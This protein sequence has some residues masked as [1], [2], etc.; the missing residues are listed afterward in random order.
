MEKRLIII[1]E[2]PTEA[3]FTNQVL[4]K[5]FAK[6]NMQLF[7]PYPK[8]SGGGD[9]D[10]KRLYKDILL[11]LKT[12]KKA[13]VTTFIDLYGLSNPSEFPG[14]K[15]GLKLSGNIYHRIAFLENAMLETI[16]DDFRY[17]FIPNYIIHEFEGLLFNDIQYFD[18][19]LE[20]NEY[21]NKNELQK[22]LQQY[23]N[24]ELI[25][26]SPQTAPSKRLEYKILKSYSKTDFGVRLAVHIGLE[27]IRT[28]CPH[29]NDWITKLENL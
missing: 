10:W 5:H 23:S 12:D 22:V 3:L 17:R 28:K 27:K 1:C 24:P 19:L 11:H 16:D 20:E 2:G 18:D 26:E 29:F 13:Y 7:T 21:K 15:E 14:W 25:N 4:R 6:R 9:I 8:W